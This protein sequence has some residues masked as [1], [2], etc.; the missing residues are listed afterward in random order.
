MWY[1]VMLR[2]SWSPR[3]GPTASKLGDSYSAVRAV[4]PAFKLL[5]HSLKKFLEDALRTRVHAAGRGV[6]ASAGIK[7]GGLR[8]MRR[9]DGVPVG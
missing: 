6:T 9:G 7:R 3:Y 1:Y 8:F 4:A 2:M 5:P